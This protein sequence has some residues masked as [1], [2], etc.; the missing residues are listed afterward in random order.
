MNSLK[1]ELAAQ[2]ILGKESR[3]LQKQLREREKEVT[4]L[5][6]QVDDLSTQLSTAQTEI[7]ALQSKLAAARNNNM[8]N[9]ASTSKIPGSAVKSVANRNGAV[10]A[11]AAEAAQAAHLA[12]LKE[13]LYSDLSGLIIR[14]VK[15]RDTDYL[16]DCIQTGANGSEYSIYLTIQTSH[17]TGHLLFLQLYISNLPWRMTATATWLLILIRPSS[18]T[19]RCWTLIAMQIWLKFYPTILPWTS[20][21]HD[22]T[23]RNFTTELLI[24]SRNDLSI[25]SNEGV[26]F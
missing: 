18:I 25:R 14:N 10:G 6:S 17:V 20:H 11:A 24:L 26:F 7:K 12:Q 4:D 23:H 15:K 21:F 3:N 22:K 19:C 13:D 2:K 8:P 16:Y 9:D 1:E 5:Q